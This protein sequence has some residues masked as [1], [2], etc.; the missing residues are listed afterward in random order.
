MENYDADD[1]INAGTGTDIAIKD[2][3]KLIAG[4]AGY[5]GKIRFDTT[6]PDGAMRKLL[7]SSR[8]KRLGWKPKVSL[9]QGIRRSL[10]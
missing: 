5:R 4:I 2:L 7:D 10:V 3:A 1:L 6:K 9:E 8:I